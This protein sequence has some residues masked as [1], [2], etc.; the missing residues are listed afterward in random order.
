MTQFWFEKTA[1]REMQ[2]K[3]HCDVMLF[4]TLL[5]LTLLSGTAAQ[6]CSTKIQRCMNIYVDNVALHPN[7]SA[8]ICQDT[9]I[10][11]KCASDECELSESQTRD[12]TAAAQRDLASQGI[13][14]VVNI[15]NLT[16]LRPQTMNPRTVEPTSCNAAISSCSRTY[17]SDVMDQAIRDTGGQQ[18]CQP[19]EK[20]VTCLRYSPCEANLI[21][22][23]IKDNIES[24]LKKNKIHCILNICT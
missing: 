10:F 24:E 4:G 3:Y 23:N 2:V 5:L 9:N 14:C 12:L 7:N 11:L 8:L 20:Y 6:D 21:S 17:L 19:I 16:T 15:N 22:S 13:R 1:T 18:I